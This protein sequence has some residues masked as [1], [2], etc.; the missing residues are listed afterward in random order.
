MIGKPKARSNGR[1]FFW[2]FSLAEQ[3]KVLKNHII[4]VYKIVNKKYKDI[5]DTVGIQLLTIFIDRG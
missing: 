5:G 2:H 1:R 4:T 3:K